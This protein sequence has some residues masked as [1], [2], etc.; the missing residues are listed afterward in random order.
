MIWSLIWFAF[1][2]NNPE[3]DHMMSLEEKQ[4]L[5]QFNDYNPVTKVIY[6]VFYIYCH[7][8]HFH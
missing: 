4:Y 2:R 3:E 7:L 5:K 1:V 6:L 8:Q